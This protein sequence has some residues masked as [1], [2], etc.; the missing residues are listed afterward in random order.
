[1]PN[2]NN[3]LDADTE[4]RSSSH[5]VLDRKVPIAVLLMLAIQFVVAI[6]GG[7]V[8][9]TNQQNIAEE[10]GRNFNEINIKFEKIE[11]TMFSRQEAVIQLESLRQTDIRYE[12]DLRQIRQDIRAILFKGVMKDGTGE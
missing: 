11:S 7:A 5:F 9:Y 12:T 1:M 6:W 10:F 4:G 3:L 8:F 2:P